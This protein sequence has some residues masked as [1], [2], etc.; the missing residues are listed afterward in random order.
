MKGVI[1]SANIFFLHSDPFS[2][3][4]SN[5]QHHYQ[6]HN[7]WTQM[8]SLAHFCHIGSSGAPDLIPTSLENVS[9]IALASSCDRC[10]SL[11]SFINPSLRPL[12]AHGETTLE[13]N[14]GN[15]DIANIFFLRKML[16]VSIQ[17][18]FLDL[19]QIGWRK[20]SVDR[21]AEA[22]TAWQKSWILAWSSLRMSEML[23]AITQ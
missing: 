7:Q 9:W 4:G 2:Q 21:L 15:R 3:P 11:S 10:R 13:T 16:L 1:I 8:A 17:T 20:S 14:M 18:H 12:L 6:Q 19:A 23:V 5:W 22:W